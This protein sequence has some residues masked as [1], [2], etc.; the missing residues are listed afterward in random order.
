MRPFCLVLVLPLIGML[1]SRADAAVLNI[2]YA[3]TDNT[4]GDGTASGTILDNGN[5]IG[6]WTISNFVFTTRTTDSV[7]PY[8]ATIGIVTTST[9]D[10]TY[11]KPG[12]G[13]RI[14]G[15]GLRENGVW[16][17]QYTV[18]WS[19]DTGYTLNGASFWGKYP[20]TVG[21]Y[22]PAQPTGN[23]GSISLSGFTGQGTV[24]DPTDNLQAADGYQ[25]NSGENLKGWNVGVIQGTPV[26]NV[27]WQLTAPAASSY[28]YSVDYSDQ[29]L[30]SANES[31]AFNLNI[32]PEPSVGSLFLVG[33]AWVL[34]RRQSRR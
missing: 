3:I 31:T 16:S 27:N 10:N 24:F 12:I 20:N 22:G 8:A 9:P 2:D 17:F 32:V 21:F 34:G 30:S 6:T 15:D 5:L 33:A 29:G 11:G 18:G 7:P 1:V 13:I 19:L 14:G 28:T 26:A 4:L 25:F 23:G